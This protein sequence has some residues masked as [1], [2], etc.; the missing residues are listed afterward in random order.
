[1]RAQ[2]TAHTKVSPISIDSV[3]QDTAN[4]GNSK[5]ALQLILQGTPPALYINDLLNTFLELYPQEGAT[6][7]DPT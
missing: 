5:G 6:G 2:I 4:A 1:M 7:K 3:A